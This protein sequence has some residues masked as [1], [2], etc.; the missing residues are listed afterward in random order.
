MWERTNTIS[1]C[2]NK[3]LFIDFQGETLLTCSTLN[4]RHPLLALRLS[5]LLWRAAGRV[6]AMP[7]VTCCAIVQ[8]PIIQQ[9]TATNVYN[10]IV[11]C[12]VLLLSWQTFFS[13]LVSFRWWRTNPLTLVFV[14]FVCQKKWAIILH[15]CVGV[16]TGEAGDY[17]R[18]VIH[19]VAT[20]N[21][22][23]W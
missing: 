7:S 9:L 11:L 8:R 12:W 23:F 16:A 15:F 20:Q 14:S 4:G 13:S 6:L 22:E 2:V 1:Q 5:F 21:I 3:L 10:E 18:I 17:R 19:S